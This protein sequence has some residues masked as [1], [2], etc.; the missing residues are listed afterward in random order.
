MDVQTNSMPQQKQKGSQK[1][2]ATKRSMNVP[3]GKANTGDPKARQQ[4]DVQRRLGSFE[5]TGNHAR[6]GSRGH[7]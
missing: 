3:H 4:H 2:F 1:S 6:T 7:Q 5:G